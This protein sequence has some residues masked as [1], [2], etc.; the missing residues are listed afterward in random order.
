MTLYVQILGG[1]WVSGRWRRRLSR[2]R[3]RWPVCRLFDGDGF[4]T[5]AKT[6]VRLGFS[7]NIIKAESSPS[8][9][10]KTEISGSDRFSCNIITA[11]SS[12]SRN[13]KSAV[14]IFMQYCKKHWAISCSFESFASGH[15]QCKSLVSTALFSCCKSELSV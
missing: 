3:R 4:Q 5:T 14:W 1:N 9:N 11:V 8:R 15:N 13:Q 7:C 6:V 2:W 12:P 10:K